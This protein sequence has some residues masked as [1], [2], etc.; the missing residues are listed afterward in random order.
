MEIIKLVASVA[1]PVA[2]AVLGWLVLRRVEGIKALVAKE[3][4]FQKK[5]A[6]EFFVCGQQF[7]QALE[8]EL[9]LLTVLGPSAGSTP[10]LSEELELRIRLRVVFAPLS[11]EA[12][13]QAAADC[14]ERTRKLLTSH[15][16]NVDEIIRTMDGF[17]RACKRAHAEMLGLN[18]APHA[19]P[20]R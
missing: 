4:E 9:A 11:A 7:M 14:M 1:T 20:K 12:V 6:D 17:N 10:S 3:S 2:V 18:D 16:G 13:K 8:K 15:G 5:W 19:S